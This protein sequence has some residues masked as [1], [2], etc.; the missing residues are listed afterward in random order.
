MQKLS[1][2]ILD[3][4]GSD[5][6]VAPSRL[7]RWRYDHPEGTV[8][9][10]II[11]QP[12]EE[13]VIVVVKVSLTFMAWGDSP[14]AV[15]VD[16]MAELR[17]SDEDE[18]RLEKTATHALGRALEAAGYPGTIYSSPETADM[19]PQTPVVVD[20]PT[21]RNGKMA[22]EPWAVVVHFARNK[23]KTLRE[24]YDSDKSSWK[25]LC[26]WKPGA[27]GYKPT[28]EDLDLRAA[29]D[30]IAAEKVSA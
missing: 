15:T 2:P 4:H 29:L 17:E 6:E 22:G 11:S 24:V 5:Y 28:Q 14:V 13:E 3:L 23:G 20:D 1:N 10:E 27:N 25:W 19:A 21:E 12:V 7:Q 18:K 8:A 16:G 30:A 26:D 9:H